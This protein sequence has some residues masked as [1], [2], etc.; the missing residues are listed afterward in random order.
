MCPEISSRA[1]S[2]TL[3]S[4]SGKSI[5]ATLLEKIHSTTQPLTSPLSTESAS[6]GEGG[7]PHSKSLFRLFRLFRQRPLR[8][9]P[10]DREQFYF[11]THLSLKRN[12]TFPHMPQMMLTMP[13][14]QHRRLFQ[15]LFLLIFRMN[16]TSLPVCVGHTIHH[17]HPSLVHALNDA[18]GNSRIKPDITQ[19]GPF[20][21]SIWFNVGLVLCQRQLKSDQSIHVTIGHVMDHLSSRPALRSVW[22]FQLLRRQF[23]KSVFE[24]LRK[25]RNGGSRFLKFVV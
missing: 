13:C 3:L 23:L 8:A 25:F 12:T 1:V 4:I 21:L 18:D 6:G 5:T 22:A 20:G 14:I 16:E 7:I 19:I 11:S 9:A 10:I 15:S 2:A 17:G 24:S